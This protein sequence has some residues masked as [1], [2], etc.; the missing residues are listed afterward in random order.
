MEF[1]LVAPAVWQSVLTERD[2]VSKNPNDGEAWG[3]LAK[4]YKEI[5]F[6]SKGYRL[7][8]G[9]E[10][11]YTS[12]IEA[13]EKSLSLEPNDAQWHAGFADLLAY[14]SVFGG[15][16]DEAQRALQEMHT[17]LQLAPNDPKVL[18]IAKDLSYTLPEGI[19][20]NGDRFDFPSLTQAPTTPT[21]LR[22]PRLTSSPLPTKTPQPTITTQPT[23]S[24]TIPTPSSKSPSSLCGSAMLIPLIAIIWL[25]W[26]RK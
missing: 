3:R 13:Y 14:H 22:T 24:I 8:T 25:G 1:A 17:A 10:E 18:E 2:N 7:D 4:S 20:Q 16:K 19:V 11:L 6:Y 9:G 12:S 23:P 26:K 15:T 5:F 21:L